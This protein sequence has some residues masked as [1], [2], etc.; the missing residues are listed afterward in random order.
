MIILSNLDMF[1]DVDLTPLEHVNIFFISQF[2]GIIGV[3][4]HKHCWTH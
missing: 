1:L 3:T 2:Q 4:S